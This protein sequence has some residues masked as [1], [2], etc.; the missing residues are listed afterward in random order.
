MVE[1]EWDSYVT[2]GA[3]AV[4]WRCTHLQSRFVGGVGGVSTT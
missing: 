4:Q 3:A 1:W 2:E